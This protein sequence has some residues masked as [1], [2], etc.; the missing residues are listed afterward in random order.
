MELGRVLEKAIGTGSLRVT[1]PQGV[2]GQISRKGHHSS[3]GTQEEGNPVS[4]M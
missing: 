1:K 4:A 2:F 3:S